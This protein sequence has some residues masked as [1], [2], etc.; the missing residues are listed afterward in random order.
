MALVRVSP[1]FGYPLTSVALRL[2]LLVV[3]GSEFNGS[4]KPPH[5]LSK[6]AVDLRRDGLEVIML[7]YDQGSMAHALFFGLH[8]LLLGNAQ[9]QIRLPDSLTKKA[10]FPAAGTIAK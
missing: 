8:Q 6:P 1:I 10:D 5:R 2:S 7:I 3:S 9:L 4:F